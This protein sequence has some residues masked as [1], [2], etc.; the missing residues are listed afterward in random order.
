MNVRILAAAVTLAFAGCVS[1]NETEFP[2]VS[3]T[4]LPADRPAKVQL[5]GFDAVITTYVPVYG[6]TT[7]VGGAGW[8]GPHHRYSCTPYASTV[9]TET[10]VPQAS[11]TT[12]FR[13][14]ACEA[15]ERSGCVLQAPDPQY[16]LEVTFSG[17][18][19]TDGDTWT[20]VAWNVFTLLTADYA[21]QLWT[22]KLKI[23]DVRTGRL[24]FF[25]DYEQRY[26]VT[27]WGPIPIFSPGAS[28]KTKY[29]AVQSW[30]LTALTD[31]TLADALV[32]FGKDALQGKEN[33][34]K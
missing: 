32:F 27:V 30:C 22:A 28:S 24:V 9:T 3:L 21:T 29:T 15:L 19:I 2:V 8:Y 11:P 14:R 6:Y 26:A 33:V 18:V 5:A 12:V 17:P 13:D 34:K 23:H 25:R 20:G 1:F 16:R 4:A 10:I 7:V 31:R